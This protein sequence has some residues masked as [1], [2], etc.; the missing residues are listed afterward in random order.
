LWC[1]GVRPLSEF[2]LDGKRSHGRACYCHPCKRLRGR[3]QNISKAYDTA[4]LRAALESNSLRERLGASAETVLSIIQ[5][6]KPVTTCLSADADV[7]WAGDNPMV[8]RAAAVRQSQHAA[9][10]DSAGD[11]TATQQPPGS[12]SQPQSLRIKRDPNSTHVQDPQPS[13]P[14]TIVPLGSTLPGLGSNPPPGPPVM[15]ARMVAMPVHAGTVGS[16]A[17][18]GAGYVQEAGPGEPQTLVEMEGVSVAVGALTHTVLNE[19]REYAKMCLAVRER[20]LMPGITEWQ[21][22]VE[23]QTA[24]ELESHLVDLRGMLSKA[25]LG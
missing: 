25:F 17:C 5:A 13:A 19:V 6:D 11:Y 12:A 14:A 7:E 18:G 9:H 16:G 23:R 4:W 10:N 8:W 24:A 1:R 2:P 22:E 15:H 3:A 20:M 21:L